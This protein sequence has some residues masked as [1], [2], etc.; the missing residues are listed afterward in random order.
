[1]TKRDEL[2]T[3]TLSRLRTDIEHHLCRSLS[4]PA[5]FI[6]LSDKLLAENCGYISPTTLKRVWGYISD[7]GTEYMPSKYTR[8][9][10]CKMLGYKDWLDYKENYSPLQSREYTGQF[11]ETIHLPL[12][13][14]ITLFWQPN[15]RIR[16]RHIKPSLFSVL[17]NENSSLKIGDTVECHCFTQYAPAFFRIFRQESLPVSYVAGSATGIFY[18][19]HSEADSTSER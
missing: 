5:D 18:I 1:M 10:L 8:R 2:D 11:L 19:V 6:F 16:L 4:S 7:K 13:T 14:E 15:R 17:E 9:A 12:N 3:D